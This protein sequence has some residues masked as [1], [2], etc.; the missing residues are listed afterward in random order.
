MSEKSISILANGTMYVISAIGI[1][2]TLMVAFKWDAV[3]ANYAEIDGL[4]GAAMY[5]C[6]IAFILG[7]LL[8]IGFGIYHF[9]TNLSNAKGTLIG[10]GVFLVV[11]I[12]SYFIASD[13]VLSVFVMADGSPVS[14]EMVKF[15]DTGII[16]SY[17]FG[18]LAIVAAIY[19]E[20]SRVLK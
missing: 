3:A 13:E 15:S 5:V 17:L 7:A 18:L 4:V 11:F 8:G 20:I 12:I 19:A 14:S 1:I 2:I 16:A 10:L 9:L 6:Y